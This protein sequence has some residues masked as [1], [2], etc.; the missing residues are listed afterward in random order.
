MDSFMNKS[1]LALIPSRLASRRLPGKPL[2][3]ICGMPMIVHVAKRAQLSKSIDKVYVCTDSTEIAEVCSKFNISVKITRGSYNNGT[4]RIADVAKEFPDSFIVDVQGD[5][6]LINPDNID[7]VVEFAKSSSKK[8]DIVI[9]TIQ[10]QYSSGDSVVRV[11]SST[12]NR[13]MYLTRAMTPHPFRNRP[14]FI[15]KHLSVI[16]FRPTILEKFS[17]LP[18][19]KLESFED[20]E[21]LRAIENDMNVYSLPLVANSFSVDIHDDVARVKLAMV[22]DPILLEYQ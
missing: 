21:L 2:L 18:V 8:P 1:T 10:E 14:Q 4:E 16:C 6:P 3:E 11:I 12:S 17:A 15:Q 20:V 7:E 22:N 19:S 13:V 9:P 5:E